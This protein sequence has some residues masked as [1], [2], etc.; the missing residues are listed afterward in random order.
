M[1]ATL[2]TESQYVGK[3]HGKYQVSSIKT[4]VVL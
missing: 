4:V 1:T 2:V 3:Y